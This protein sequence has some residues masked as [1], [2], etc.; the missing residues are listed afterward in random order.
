VFA[1]TV[2]WAVRQGIETATFHILTPYPGTAL[3]R[4]LA[5]EG[6]I[7]HSNWDLNDTRHVVF[8]PAHMTAAQLEA[9][10]R[11][12]YREFYS[13]PAIVRSAWSGD[14]ARDRLRH[15][16]YTA[17][18]KKMEPVWDVAIRH[19]H[20][21]R[22]LPLLETLL[23]SP[24]GPTLET[25]A[26]NPAGPALETPPASPAGPALGAGH[27]TTGDERPTLLPSRGA[28]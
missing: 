3:S 18:W 23:A 1:R 2:D 15:L 10:Y 6:R 22:L 17:G 20:V 5:A 14:G 11:R 8:R 27:R 16:A 26:G 21:Q 7:A 28:A 9:G 25:S 13:W 24:A 12:V 4:R 19:G